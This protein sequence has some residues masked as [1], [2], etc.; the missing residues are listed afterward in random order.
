MNRARVIF[1]LCFAVISCKQHTFHQEFES[2]DI[3]NFWNAYDQIVQSRDTL[4]QKNYLKSL[5]LAKGSEGL[6]D[7][8]DV[9][10]YSED[11]FLNAIK[12]YPEFWKSIRANTLRIDSYKKEIKND[13]EKLRKAY[14]DLQP[15]KI[16]FTMGAF[17]TNGTIKGSNVLIG[18]EL[19]L[20]DE[21]TITTELPEWRRPFYDQYKPLEN[22][23]LLCTHEYIHTQ[24]KELVQNLLS[25]CLYEGVAE[26]ISCH[27]TKKPSSSPAIAFGKE[28]EKR[29]VDQFVSDLYLI[30]N[31]YNWLWGRN[32]NELK[33]RDLGYYIGYEICERYYHQSSDKAKAIKELIELD[34]T[35]EK[36]VERIVDASKLLPKALSQLRDEYEKKRPTV[37]KILEFENGNRNVS[38][39][40]NTITVVFSE[41]LNGVQNGLDFGPKGK[42]FYPKVDNA[43]R[44][45]G[46]HNRSYTFNVALE[47]NKNYQMMIGSNFRLSNGIRLRPYLIEFQTG[48]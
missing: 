34:Y 16:F 24:Q 44:K 2:G 35:D 30:S 42:E 15:A 36:V 19:A 3:A 23:A 45:W 18:S 5:Y 41:A 25:M 6:K 48:K 28:N 9:R 32:R 43:S 29:V 8:I 10:R 4:T 22:L 27:V 12:S 31:N 7:L 37:V 17:K 14:P 40:V 39:N 46:D 1:A 33:I 21:H 38:S 47:P 11:E 20:A 26:F 13:I